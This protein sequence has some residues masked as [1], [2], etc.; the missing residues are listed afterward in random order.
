MSN[1]SYCR[2]ENTL[3]D[4]NDCKN[5]LDEN[6]FE[7]LSDDEL[8]AAKRLIRSCQYIAENFGELAK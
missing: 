2:F 7:H 5:A 8:K 3:A 4:L 1:M 6:G